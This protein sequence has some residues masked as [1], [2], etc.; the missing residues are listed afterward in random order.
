MFQTIIADYKKEPQKAIDLAIEAL[1]NHQPIV[2]PTETVYGI[3]CRLSDLEAVKKIYEIKKR[4]AKKPL[5]A[6]ISN[7]KQ[8]N[9]L[10]SEK[11]AI[12]AEL[13]EKYLPG[14]LAII[15][16]KK[17]Y[18]SDQITSGFNTISIRYP[19]NDACLKIIDAIGEPLVATSAN[20]S[21]EPA[22]I[23]GQ[24][25]YQKLKGYIALII[26]DG[27]TKYQ[28]ESTVISIVKNKIEVLRQGVLV[29]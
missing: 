14:P 15:M 10:V 28:K 7:I 8:V 22:I 3:G 17:T 24:E 5:A 12:F 18:I 4:N 19:D 2:F 20:F 21:G 11:P 23:S 29:V 1:S 6:H 13:N 27:I 26:D 9:N 25:A 16:K